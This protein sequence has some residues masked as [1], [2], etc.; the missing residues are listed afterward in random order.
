V[1]LRLGV[2]GDGG[3]P[4]RL[5][6]RDGHR[7]D[8]VETPLALEEGLAWGF[9][10]VRGIVAESTASSRRTLGVWLEHKIALVPLGPR[11]CAVR[12]PCSLSWWSNPGAP[13]TQGRAAGMG[14]A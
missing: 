1:L 6:V 9:E 12:K 13:R 4:L 5:G 7:R 2:R 11:T 8:S 14:P 3:I 10:G